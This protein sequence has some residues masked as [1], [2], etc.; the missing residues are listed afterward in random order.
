MSKSEIKSLKAINKKFMYEMA[1]EI[2]PNVDPI[3]NDPNGN[4][5]GDK[6]PQGEIMIPKTRFDEINNKYKELAD[7][8]AEFEQAKAEEAKKKAEELGEFEKLYKSTAQD[9]EGYKAKTTQA[10]DRAKQLEN[11]VNELVENKLRDIPE[12]YKELIP[13]GMS[14]EEKLAWISKAE[15]KGLFKK[16]A[17]VEIGKPMNNGAPQIDVNKLSAQDKILFAFNSLT[18]KK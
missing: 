15:S 5:D 11:V 10:E 3:Q 1:E 17:D 2:D 14:A 18:K 9:L 12:D 6:T 13:E 8:V 16:S 7:K 4:H